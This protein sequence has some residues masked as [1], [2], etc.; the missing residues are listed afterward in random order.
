MPTNPIDTRMIM[1]G[2]NVESSTASSQFRNGNNAAINGFAASSRTDSTIGTS[3][4]SSALQAEARAFE[5]SGYEQEKRYQIEKR[6]MWMGK[7]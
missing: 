2:R 1:K 5:R 7:R 6:D 3:K 4:F